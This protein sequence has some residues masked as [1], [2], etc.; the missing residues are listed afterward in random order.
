MA[1]R[2]PG[3]PACAAVD[4]DLTVDPDT[5][6]A[7]REFVRG[8]RATPFMG[9]LAAY[10]AVLGR[11][12]G[13]ED[14]AVGSTVAGRPLPQVQDVIGMFVDRVVL[15]LDLSD[16]PTFRQLVAEA[17]Q[18]VADAH[19]HSTATFD[20]VVDAISPDR[21]IGVTPLAQASINLQPRTPGGPAESLM[22]QP[23][24]ESTLDTGH[25]AHDLVIDLVE[26]PTSYTGIV[27]YHTDVGRRR[28]RDP[29][30]RPVHPTT[31][32]RHSPIPTDHCGCSPWPPRPPSNLRQPKDRHCCTR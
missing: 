21:E 28:H 4:W 8:E 3:S 12:F 30:P 32:R 26:G 11:V 18:V 17:R 19:D 7:L 23:F 2:A 20:Q 29:G 22:P 24:A 6:A 14:V 10:A 9:L 27:G 13:T 31:A 15:R 1:D 25:V 16:G 5:T